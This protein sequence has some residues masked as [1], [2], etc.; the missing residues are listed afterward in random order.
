[1]D[2]ALSTT[3]E[4]SHGFVAASVSVVVVSVVVR[5]TVVTDGCGPL[6]P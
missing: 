3:F 1:M 6:I 2:Q 4:N 5:V